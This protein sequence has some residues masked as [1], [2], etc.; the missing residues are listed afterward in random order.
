MG[1]AA[2][3]A[4]PS[5]GTSLL[6]PPLGVGLQQGPA[7]EQ[8]RIRRRLHERSL[9]LREVQHSLVRPEISSEDIHVTLRLVLVLLV[10]LL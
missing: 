7:G 4:A 5:R 1:A 8:A 9:L 3:A 10:L 6:P 2:T